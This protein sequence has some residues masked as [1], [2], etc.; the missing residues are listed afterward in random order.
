MC[1]EL[2]E[3]QDRINIIHFYHFNIVT[4]SSVVAGGGRVGISALIISSDG[5]NP[6]GM[7]LDHE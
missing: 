6:L 7:P 5:M 2:K 1:S 4:C 3:L